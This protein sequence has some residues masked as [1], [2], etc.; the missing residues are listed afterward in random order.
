MG[1][2]VHTP[3]CLHVPHVPVGAWEGQVVSDPLELELPIVVNHLVWVLE[4]ELGP[5]EV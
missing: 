4:T 3:A 1:V 2:C 5:L